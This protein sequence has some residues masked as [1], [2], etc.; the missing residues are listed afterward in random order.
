MLVKDI[1]SNCI[2][3]L[4]YSDRIDIEKEEL[5]Q[6][7]QKIINTLLK[8]A[9]IIYAEISTAYL[10]NL[11]K[12]NVTLRNNKLCHSTLNNKLIYCVSLKQNGIARYIKQYPSYIESN[13]SGDAILEYVCLP[14]K[15]T[16]ASDIPNTI[17]FWLISNG[18]IAE[19]AYANNLIDI[20]V[21]HER[22][23]REGLSL[24]KSRGASKYIKARG[25]R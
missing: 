8:C 15:L 21:Q 13:F 17:P 19:Y 9:D 6:E 25:W 20:A 3:K 22:K 4:G 10:P 1:I 18:I 23:Y 16:L 2:L 14:E 7:E 5:S 12:E 11:T 24:M